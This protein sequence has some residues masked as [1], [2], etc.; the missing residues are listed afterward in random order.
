MVLPLS[1]IIIVEAQVALYRT[2]VRRS[3]PK[4]KVLVMNRTQGRDGQA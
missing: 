2:M 4:S 1:F 3:C